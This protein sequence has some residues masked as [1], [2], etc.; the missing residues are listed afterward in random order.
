VLA[1][2]IR[3]ETGY[4]RQPAVDHQLIHQLTSQGTPTEFGANSWPRVLSE[5]L[6]LSEGEAKRRIKQ[7]ELLG[8]RTALTGE[9]LPPVLPNV[10]S[11]AAARRDRARTRADHREVLR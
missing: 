6:R 7:A 3:L 11:G 8:P 4:R 1:I 2:Q 5:A 10:A 9:T